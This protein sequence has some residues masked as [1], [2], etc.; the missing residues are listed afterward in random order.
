[1]LLKLDNLLDEMAPSKKGPAVPELTLPPLL[2]TDE[3]ILVESL[4]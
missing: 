2:P 3:K 1:M 4:C